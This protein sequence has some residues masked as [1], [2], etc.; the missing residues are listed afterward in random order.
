MWEGADQDAAAPIIDDARRT[1]FHAEDELR[2]DPPRLMSDYGGT[3]R[4]EQNNLLDWEARA[5]GAGFTIG[6]DGAVSWPPDAPMPLHLTPAQL[7]GQRQG[8][9]DELTAILD[10]ATQADG[11]FRG[12]MAAFQT[13]NLDP[14][15][16]GAADR[17]VEADGRR[18]AE[19]AALDYPDPDQLA[20]LDRLLERNGSDPTFAAEFIDELGPEGLIEHSRFIAGE[21]GESAQPS[22]AELARLQSLQENLGITLAT[23]TDPNTEPRLDPSFSDELME[24]GRQ[25]YG[26]P[27][28]SPYG[29]QYLAPLLHYGTYSSEFLQP[30]GDDLLRMERENPNIWAESAPPDFTGENLAVDPALGDSWDPMDGFASALSRNG[31]AAA[32]FYAPGGDQDRT[33]G[34]RIIE[35]DRMQYM[36]DRLGADSP[37]D[38]RDYTANFVGDSIE[39]AALNEPRTGREAE[40]AERFVQVYGDEAGADTTASGQIDTQLPPEMRHNMAAVLGGYIGDVND[41]MGATEAPDRGGDHANFGRSAQ[42][43]QILSRMIQETAY[44]PAAYAQLF[45]AQ[46]AYTSLTLNAEAAQVDDGDNLAERNPIFRGHLDAAGGVFE[47]LDAGRV[48]AIE[49]GAVADAAA[50]NAEVS[51]NIQYGGYALGAATSA[52]PLPPVI[53]SLSSAAQAEL[54]NQAIQGAQ[55]DYSGPANQEIANVHANTRDILRE[56]VQQATW[57]NLPTDAPIPSELRQY[58]GGPPIP[59]N[60]MTRDQNEEILE[61]MRTDWRFAGYTN[62]LTIFLDER[63]DPGGKPE[64][65]QGGP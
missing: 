11:E 25:Q 16:V 63:Y 52:L 62:D 30:I 23:A 61:M 50:Y 54:I 7:D 9:A 14:T 5:A 59:I 39:A 42:D 48:E 32:D 51:R 17:Q 18:A 33:P 35:P 53:G 49:Q 47:A 2:T 27:G 64:E 55:A 40:I 56:Q 37:Y 58:P 31:D 13:E 46:H 20:E 4:V 41:T 36:A 3:L 65:S 44:D 38:D 12:G 6:P 19:L 24:A 29:Y 21:A 57:D 45:Q 15:V 8:Y 26:V 10:R 28:H 43:S 60:E 22:P 1:L 34:E